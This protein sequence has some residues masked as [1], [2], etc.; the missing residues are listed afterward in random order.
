MPNIKRP[1][2]P[3]ALDDL[4]RSGWRDVVAGTIEDGYSGVW[5]RLS[6]AAEQALADGNEGKARALWSLADACSMMLVPTNQTEPFQAYCQTPE[7]RSS[8]PCDFSPEDLD[9]LGAFVAHVDEP[10]LRARL[11][12]LVWFQ[13]TPRPSEMLLNAVDAYRAVHPTREA[14]RAGADKGWHRALG[15]VRMA[16]RG[17]GARPQEMEAVLLSVFDNAPD[18]EANWKLSLAKLMLET[19]LARDRLADIAEHLADLGKRAGAPGDGYLARDVFALARDFFKQLRN[20]GRMADMGFAIA[21]SW[22]ADAT[23]RLDGT[24]PSNIIAASFFESAMQSFRSVPHRE[25]ARLNV[26]ARLQEVQAQLSK[27]GSQATT[28][29]V[30]ISSPSIDVSEIVEHARTAVSGKDK[31]MALTAFASLWLGPN[32]AKLRSDAQAS[33]QRFQLS[34]FFGTTSFSRDG[35]VIARQE[36][37]SFGGGDDTE[38]RLLASM[39]RDF[40]ITVGLV[41][42]SQMLPGIDVLRAEHRYTPEDFVALAKESPFIP[43]GREV[44]VAKGLFAGLSG[45]FDIALHLLAPQMENLV[46]YHLKNAGMLTS[47]V[48]PQGIEN[49]LGL[50]TLMALDGVDDVLSPNLAFEIRAMFCNPHGPNLRN[51]VAH[52]LLDDD[53][54]NSLHSAYAWWMMLRMVFVAWWNSKRAQSASEAATDATDEGEGGQEDGAAN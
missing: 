16:G 40:Q 49:E 54:S 42:Q 43:S 39:V 45:D 9:V 6:R 21:E 36:A 46:R 28:E 18:T 10:W 7:G 33:S 14:W 17:A 19:G 22:V 35:R 50:S 26:G 11:A 52:G 20:E 5:L 34:R 2:I 41:V 13:K 32:V 24:T 27:A 37:G 3:L 48:D 23:A 51:D 30:A 31:L 15:L 29:M 4:I 53:Q 1:D 47:R 12:D 8:L 25:R 44:L 38:E